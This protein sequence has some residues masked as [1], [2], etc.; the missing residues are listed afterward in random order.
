MPRVSPPLEVSGGD[1]KN[2]SISLM[3]LVPKNHKLYHPLNFIG[4]NYGSA[5][6]ITKAISVILDF[7]KGLKFLTNGKKFTI[8]NIFNLFRYTLPA[9]LYGIEM[10]LKIKKYINKINEKELSEYDKRQKKLIEFLELDTDNISYYETKFLNEEIIFWLL[11][12]PN[13]NGY[14]IIGYFDH[15]FKPLEKISFEHEFNEIFV[16]VEFNEEK[17]L[18]DL[19]ITKLLTSYYCDLQYILNSTYSAEGIIKNLE[20]LIIKNFI[21]TFNTQENI[22]EYRNGL[23]TR[24]RLKIEENI[25]QY[26]VHSLEKEIRKILKYHRKRGY[27]L[28]GFQGTGKT[29]IIK[30]LEE[31]LTDI[32]IIKLGPEEFQSVHRIKKCFQ[33]VKII[34]PALVIIEDLDALGFKEKNERVGAFINEIDDSNNDLNIVLLVTINDTELVHRTIID[35]PGRFD[36]I[37]EI[38]PPQSE[39]EAYEVMVSKFNKLKHFYT[40]FKDIDFPSQEKM[41]KLLVR[42]L[43]N[44]F[45]QAELTSGI[46]EKVFINIDHPNTAYLI[47]E[48]EKAITFFEKS[49]KSLKTYTFNEKF[50]YEEECQVDDDEKMPR[51]ETARN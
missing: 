26:D 51:P 2:E 5:A 1:P 18:F 19:K 4:Q 17:I 11:K 25:N 9:S 46:V 8:K 43:N 41:K 23:V 7:D 21:V 22:L 3:N 44:K 24:K 14:K 20:T 30:K 34:Q 45:T 49:K 40:K 12:S 32:T 50:T 36:E 48:I 37:I 13:T 28:I 27:G 35:R 15:S 6:D 29:I 38:K 33:F 31:I 47:T 42:C 16:L 10:A 39:I